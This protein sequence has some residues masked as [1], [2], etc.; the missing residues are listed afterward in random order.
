MRSAEYVL[1]FSDSL[2]IDESQFLTQ[3][4]EPGVVAPVCN[5]ST[6][7][8]VAGGLWVQVNLGYKPR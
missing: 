1:C 7:K 6:G 4:Q 5:L 2:D 3:S 8:A